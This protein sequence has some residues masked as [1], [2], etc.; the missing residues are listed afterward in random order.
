MNGVHLKDHLSWPSHV[1]LT[2]HQS[3]LYWLFRE[4]SNLSR[5]PLFYLSGSTMVNYGYRSNH[6]ANFSTTSP[7]YLNRVFIAHVIHFPL[8]FL[9][10]YTHSDFSRTSSFPPL[11]AG[12]HLRSVS[13]LTR[14]IFKRYLYDLNHRAIR[15]S[16]SH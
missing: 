14:R 8:Y 16:C 15:N 13:S 3:N 12:Q 7:T 9:F 1:Y 6:L 10:H 2:K 11:S 4:Y 5:T